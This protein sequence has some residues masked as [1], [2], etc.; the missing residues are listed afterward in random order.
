MQI[1]EIERLA[2]IC[3]H[4]VQYYAPLFKLMAKQHEIKVFYASKSNEN[5]FDIGFG[6]HI[7]WDV[8]LLKG[9]TYVFS[10]RLKDIHDYRPTAILIYGWAYRSHFKIILH[11]RKRIMLLFRG[12]STLLDPINRWRAILK[13]YLLRKIYAKIDFALYVGSNNKAYF[14]KFGLATT[15][16]I[17]A[18]HAVDNA[19]FA[20]TRQLEV[21]KL[22]ASLAIADADILVLFA[23]KLI[24]KKQPELLLKAFG[25]L[26][27]PGTHLLLVGDGILGETL[28]KNARELLNQHAIHFLPFQNQQRMPVIYQSGD[29]FC[30]PSA[31][32]GE[33]WGLAINEAMA[34]RTA[35]LV[36]DKVGGA[37]DLIDDNN[38]QKFRSGCLEDLSKKLRIMLASKRKLQVMGQAS[39]EKIGNWN[40]QHQIDAIHG[41]S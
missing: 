1:P 40:F 33:T 41:V 37:A 9:Y 23:G 15:Q 3:Q 17:Y 26:N 14:E 19:R 34:A 36:S 2:I 28:K 5:R 32:P 4:P 27:I 21:A 10:H 39:G 31:G 11:F 25:N 30:M 24:H 35:I 18:R 20:A 8:P 29:L 16:L 38:G 12:D 22:R 7:S 6:R 13:A